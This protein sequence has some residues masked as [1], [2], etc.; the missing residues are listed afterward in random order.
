[1]KPAT[2]VPDGQNNVIARLPEVLQLD[3]RI[4]AAWLEGSFA[5]GTAD[6]WSDV[7][8]HV[9]VHDDDWDAFVVSRRQVIEQVAP[10]ISSVDAKMPW[11]AELTAAT[12]VGGIRLDLYVEKRSMLGAALRR[13]GPLLL[14]D[15]DDVARQLK[16]SWSPDTIARI[17]LAEALRVFFYGSTFPVRLWGREEW[18]SLLTNAVLVVYQF[19]VP[20]MMIAD[21]SDDA[22]RPLLHNERFLSP[23]RRSQVDK[24]IAEI[25]AAFTPH[26][27]GEPDFA[28]LGSMHERLIGAIWR[29]LYAAC[30][31]LGVDY[32]ADAERE[33]QEYYA[34]EMGWDI[35]R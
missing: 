25:V 3:D 5:R 28:A 34:R 16:V 8:L 26:A 1:M 10:I 12:I 22:F 35:K 7:D 32:P 24:L 2:Q 14:F 9:A 15:R 23:E 27:D 20:A 33:M 29:E 17:A 18:G 13:D 4:L 30:E 11:G 6:A 19:L 21:G 31:R